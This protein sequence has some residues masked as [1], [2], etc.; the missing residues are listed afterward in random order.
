MVQSEAY[1]K[2]KTNIIIKCKKEA[3]IKEYDNIIVKIRNFLS[4]GVD[5]PVYPL[6]IT[7]QSEEHVSY[8][9]NIKTFNAIEI[10]YG[11]IIAIGEN[12]AIIPPEMFFT[13]KDISQ[14]FERVIKKWFERSEALSPVFD[15]YFSNVYTPKMYDETRFLNAVQAIES[16]H[17]RSETTN[18]FD[19]DP[20]EHDKRMVKTICF[21]PIEY[22]EWLLAKLKYSNEI[23]LSQR[24]KEVISSHI[25]IAEFYIGSKRDQ[26]EFIRLV[27][28]TRNFLTHFDKRSEA[29]RARGANL[30]ILIDKIKIVIRACLLKEIGISDPEIAA[31]L[32]RYKE[33]S[34]LS[35]NL[36]S[37]D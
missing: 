4:F 5:E 6:S 33:K 28:D 20:K 34:F 19:I 29:K 30:L 15:L 27:V 22:K 37:W 1:I 17:R 23:S 25:E 12:K 26:K 9:N 18:K 36:I 7:G 31:I 16:Y 10:F 24:L 2:Q 13:F 32:R 8:Y 35:W 11:R 14:S 21:A 3:S